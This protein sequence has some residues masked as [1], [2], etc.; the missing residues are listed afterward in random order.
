VELPPG[1]YSVFTVEEEGL[2]ANE[3][4]SDGNMFPVEVLDGEFT[5]VT[6]KINYKA[7]F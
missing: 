5:E 2:Y 6:I 4:D 7:A 3:Y 1:K